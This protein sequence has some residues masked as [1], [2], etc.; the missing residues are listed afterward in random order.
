MQHTAVTDQKTLVEDCPFAEKT[1]NTLE[2]TL[3]S[4]QWPYTLSHVDLGME[5]LE[6]SRIRNNFPNIRKLWRSK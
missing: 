4:L 5:I 6:P 3:S 1:S 2:P